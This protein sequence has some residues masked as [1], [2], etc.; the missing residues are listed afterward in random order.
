MRTHMA[1]RKLAAVLSRDGFHVLRFDYYGTGDSAGES[2]DGT[3]AEWQADIVSAIADLKDCS[4]ATKVSLVG[5]RLGA[6]LAARAPVAVANL[7]LWEPV[8]EGPAYLEQLRTIHRH[9]FAD[10]LFPI[11]VPKPGEGGDLLGFPLTA[12]MEAEIRSLDV[13][14]QMACQAE[15]IVL[16]GSADGEDKAMLDSAFAGRQN[17]TTACERHVVTERFTS[18]GDEGML[19]ST[20]AVHAIASA[21]SRRLG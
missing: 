13:L 21:L 6:A 10:L 12:A 1:L 20:Q 5:L 7:V 19:L 17:G 11:P 2:T 15:H 18:D 8:L 14:E 9:R 16:V 3:L 4:G